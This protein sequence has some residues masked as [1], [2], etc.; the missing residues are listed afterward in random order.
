MAVHLIDLLLST[1][2]LNELTALYDIWHI[3]QIPSS[4]ARGAGLCPALKPA[5]APQLPSA[6][7]HALPIPF[8][9]NLDEAAMYAKVENH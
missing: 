4:S 9:W 6:L 1:R 7:I 5:P 8:C 2:K 3:Q